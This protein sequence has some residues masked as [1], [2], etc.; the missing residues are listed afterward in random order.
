MI[1]IAIVILAAPLT[2]RLFELP[3]SDL[4]KS[5]NILGTQIKVACVGDSIT[6]DSNYPAYLQ[7]LLGAYYE[8]S[9]CFR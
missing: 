3:H 6:E 5:K 2:V 4:S 7:S 8:K 1:T 9:N